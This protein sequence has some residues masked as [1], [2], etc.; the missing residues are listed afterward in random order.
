[1]DSSRVIN[2]RINVIVKV[3]DGD[4]LIGTTD[5]YDHMI[6]KSLQLASRAETLKKEIENNLA[7]LVGKNLYKAGYT[8]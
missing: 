4:I 8:E 6:G 1:M 3:R 2:P 7:R 5:Q